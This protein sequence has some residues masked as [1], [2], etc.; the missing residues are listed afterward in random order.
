[1]ETCDVFIPFINEAIPLTDS[2]K[3]GNP[4]TINDKNS[5]TQSYLR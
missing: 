1:M 2:E 3:G 4:H 5:K